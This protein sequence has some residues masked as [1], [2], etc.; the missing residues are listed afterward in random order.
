MTH[1]KY[2]YQILTKFCIEA[3]NKLGFTEEDSKTITDVLITADLFGIESHGMQR[4]SRYDNGIQKGL[5]KVDAVPETVFETPVS[6][7]IDAH[8]G[9]GQVVSVNAMKKAIDKAKHNGIAI[10]TVRNSNHY[11]IAGYYAKMASDQNMIGFSCTNSEA[12]MVPTFGKQAMLGSN[13]IA[14]AV[15]ADPYPFL[16]DASTTVVTRGKLEMYNKAE[17]EL[18]DNWALNESGLPSNDAGRVLYNIVNKNGGGILPLGGYT[19]KSGGHKGYG[20]GMI[21]EILSSILSQGITSNHTHTDGKGGTCH[22]FIAIDPRI[23]GNPEAIKNHFS[24][25][26]NELRDSPKAEGQS[27]I[28][29]HGEKEAQSVERI[30]RE[31]VPVDIKTVYEMKLLADHAGID[32]SS[33]FGEIPQ[34]ENYHSLY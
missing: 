18:P 10:V 24:F 26:L 6:A 5:I 19:E 3:F 23:F 33:Y 34:V 16:Y 31:G 20:Y 25:F 21:C 15:P 28:Y 12:I 22:C 8:D 11:G 29:T 30:K 4:L 17:K 7:V 2:D 14:F 9:M 32:F 13:P 27:R 1:I